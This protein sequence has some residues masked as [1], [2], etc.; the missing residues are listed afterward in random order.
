MDTV[1]EDVFFRSGVQALQKGQ[2]EEA[3]RHFELAVAQSVATAK[4]WLGLALAQLSLG[5]RHGAE[6][7]IDEVLQDEPQNL[8]ALIIKGD[9]LMGRQASKS[10][11]AYYGAALQIAQYAPSI[12]PPLA[13]DLSRIA[14]VQRRLVEEFEAYLLAQ[15]NKAGYQRRTASA[16]FNDSLAMLLGEKTRTP[17]TGRF[18]QSPRVYYM[19][20][21]PY[22]TFYPEEQLPWLKDLEG[23]FVEIEEELCAVLKQHIAA[24][25]PYVHSGIHRPE[26]QA[27]ELMNS[28]DWTSAYL[29]ESGVANTDML[30]RCPKTTELLSTFPL[31]H[32]KGFLPSVLFSKLNPGAHITPHTGMLNTRLICHLPLLVPEGCGLRVGEDTRQTKEGVAWAFDDSINHEAWNYS[33][34]HR[35]I[36]LFD[37]W[38]PELTADERHLVTAL[39]EAV[40][41]YDETAQFVA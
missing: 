40:S 22:H 33:P 19:P 8:R 23:A 28:N 14:R 35:V 30:S 38:R 2:A 37:V 26:T 17:E 25:T 39:L 15:L 18:P 32:I 5:D 27:S 16:R 3:K 6:Q 20:D 31:T 7:A 21:L 36:L 24:F 41:S 29:W 34:Y 13:E 1:T 10:A 12:P 11:V 9:L 4:T